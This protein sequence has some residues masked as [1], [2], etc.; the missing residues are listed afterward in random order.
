LIVSKYES[1]RE[2]P[3][4]NCPKTMKELPFLKKD[5]VV[6]QGAFDRLL[7]E[8]DQERERAGE[9]YEQI[10]QKL[11]KFFQW[12]GC[13]YSSA[14]EYTDRTI[15]RVARKIEEGAEIH[16]QNP[17][18]YFHGIAINVL[19]E[20]WKKAGKTEVGALDE[21]SPSYTPSVNPLAV[22][23][24]EDARFEREARLECLGECVGGLSA[25]Q[26]EMIVEYHRGAGGA[27]IAQR[28]ELAERL[29]LPLNA[30]RIRM[31]RLRGEVEECINGCAKRSKKG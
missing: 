25:E 22:R 28:K 5:W 18:L 13:S 14:E 19:R 29:K 26:R 1:D 27:K 20:H 6:T 23:D 3:G 8:L 7:G 16:A 21:L 11:L 15:D 10:R 17:Y 30:L 31:Y 2:A 4:I 24:A 12:R 9:K